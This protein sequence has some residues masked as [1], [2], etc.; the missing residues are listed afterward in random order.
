MPEGA[1]AGEGERSRLVGA[2]SRFLAAAAAAASFLALIL[3]CESIF[4]QF[5]H[6]QS[7][8]RHFEH[9]ES[10]NSILSAKQIELMLKP[11]CKY[12]Q[13]AQAPLTARRQRRR[14]AAAAAPAR[15]WGHSNARNLTF[16]YDVRLRYRIRV[17]SKKI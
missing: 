1:G 7:L 13:S 4:W 17:H 2:A 9:L 10:N 6:C 15:L 11:F 12:L 16:R 3:L 8:G 14:L 5:E